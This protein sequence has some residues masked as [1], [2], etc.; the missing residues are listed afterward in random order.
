MNA[1]N[2]FYSEK[3]QKFHAFVMRVAILR[4]P[5]VLVRAKSRFDSHSPIF[6]LQNDIAQIILWRAIKGRINNNLKQPVLEGASA[7]P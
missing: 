1:S 7:L 5:V 3:L 4:K 6:R 2:I